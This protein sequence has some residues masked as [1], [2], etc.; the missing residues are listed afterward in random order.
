M[1]ITT[2]I[3]MYA[4]ILMLR[5]YDVPS[6]CYNY[7][8]P[9]ANYQ[10]EFLRPP[11]IPTVYQVIPMK[12]F[13]CVSGA[14]DLIVSRLIGSERY[15]IYSS[16]LP[17]DAISI[18]NLLLVLMKKGYEDI[19][20]V[21][22]VHLSVFYAPLL[23]ASNAYVLS[24]LYPAYEKDY[25]NAH[26]P[27]L[28]IT[29]F[30]HLNIFPQYARYFYDVFYALMLYL[31]S[32]VPRGQKIEILLLFKPSNYKSYLLYIADSPLAH[33]Y[34]LVFILESYVQYLFR[35]RGVGNPNFLN[36]SYLIFT[37][38]FIL[39]RRWKILMKQKSH[40]GKDL[41]GGL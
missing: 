33:F 9:E 20:S 38:L 21:L 1:P 7:H 2:K 28:S 37:C 25:E 30:F 3:L 29:W 15:F 17:A 40:A 23:S 41:G 12:Y 36:W 5:S 34:L 31:F 11:A 10:Q 6:L 4:L 18:E 19:A 13:T 8:S 39:E 14:C 35:V 22:L 26:R 24:Y 32:I 27:S 16:F